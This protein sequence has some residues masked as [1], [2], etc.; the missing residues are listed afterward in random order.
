MLFYEC[1]DNCK[2]NRHTN[3][4]LQSFILFLSVAPY[5]VACGDE[6][7]LVI[8]YSDSGIITS[9]K[10]PNKYPNN[11]DCQWHIKTDDGRKVQLTFSTF[12]LE[13]R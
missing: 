8:T 10:Y 13:D 3:I 11:L 1:L 12:D 2:Q 4:S 9:P 5:L 7:P 6:K